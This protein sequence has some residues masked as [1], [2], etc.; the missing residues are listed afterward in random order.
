MFAMKS[1]VVVRAAVV[2]VQNIDQKICERLR[3]TVSELPCQFLLISR[4][5]LYVF[6]CNA[7]TF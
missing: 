5:L 2:S 3:L 1:E 7:L 6:A 4:R